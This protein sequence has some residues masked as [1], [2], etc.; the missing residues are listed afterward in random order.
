MRSSTPR[1]LTWYVL[2]YIWCSVHMYSTV[3]PKQLTKYYNYGNTDRHTHTRT[4]ARTHARTDY[5]RNWVL[6]LLGTLIHWYYSGRALSDLG[7]SLL[8]STLC[9]C[10]SFL[11]GE[12]GMTS[13]VF[14]RFCSL[15]SCLF[16]PYP[17]WH[18]C[19]RIAKS[20]KLCRISGNKLTKRTQNVCLKRLAD[21]RRP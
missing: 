19:R 1:A 5:S 21:T 12:A 17:S 9:R 15:F 18:T 8:H 4:H 11:K 16:R 3:L 7:Q 2:A 13:S 14:S 10:F 6:I 20:A